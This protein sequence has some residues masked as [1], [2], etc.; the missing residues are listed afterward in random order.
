MQQL[1]ADMLQN[2]GRATTEADAVAR[3]LSEGVLNGNDARGLCNW[4]FEGNA[5][6]GSSID[7]MCSASY[8]GYTIGFT[9]NAIGHAVILTECVYDSY[10]KVAGYSYYDPQNGITG[11]VSKSSIDFAYNARGT[12]QYEF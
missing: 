5:L 11:Y 8:N 2:D 4:L 6:F 10:S 3:V 9:N 12:T 1:Y 7:A